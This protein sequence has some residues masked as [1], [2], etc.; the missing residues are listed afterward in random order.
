MADRELPERPGRWLGL[1]IPIGTVWSEETAFRG[2]LSTVAAEGFGVTGGRVLQSAIFGATHVPDALRTGDNIIGTV[3]ATG[4]AGWIFALLRE[5]S[6]SL[7]APIL[8][9]LAI[10]EAGA[11]A[12]LAVRRT[13]GGARG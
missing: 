13:S 5:R 11:V 12:A 4:L 6:G 2:A 8:A 9:H 1:E 7:L 3:L 10:N